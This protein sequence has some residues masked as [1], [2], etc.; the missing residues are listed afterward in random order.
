MEGGSESFEDLVSRVRNGVIIY[1]TI[2]EWLSNPV[3]GYLNATITYGEL[4]E[5]G[6]FRGVIRGAII[7]GNF[8]NLLKESIEGLSK[9]LGNIYGYYAPALMLRDATISSR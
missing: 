7:S 5:D 9:E 8:Y 3:S 2:G 6:V 4:L 1:E